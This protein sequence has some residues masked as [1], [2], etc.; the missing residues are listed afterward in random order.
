MRN[1]RGQFVKGESGN[2]NGRPTRADEQFLVDLWDKDGKKVFS[3][4]I[5]NGDP[6]G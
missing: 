3:S 6:N 4:A 1:K 2:P 5:E